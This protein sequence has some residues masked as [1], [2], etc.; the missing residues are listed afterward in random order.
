[1]E[2]CE[3]RWNILMLIENPIKFINKK[4]STKFIEHII[5]NTAIIIIICQTK[6]YIS[7]HHHHYQHHIKIFNDF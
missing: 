1:M 2:F 6:F 5:L 7:H 4:S 3:L